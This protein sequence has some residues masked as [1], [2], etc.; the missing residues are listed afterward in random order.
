VVKPSIDGLSYSTPKKLVVADFN[1][2]F[3]GFSFPRRK[4]VKLQNCIIV[5]NNLSSSP[6]V[7]IA[8]FVWSN[9][10]STTHFK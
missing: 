1:A 7:W 8:L 3:F 2:V 4:Y 5:Q 10:P 6:A 9:E